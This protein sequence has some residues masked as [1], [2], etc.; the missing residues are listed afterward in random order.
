MSHQATNGTIIV[1]GTYCP[2]SPSF[3]DP[4]YQVPMAA[5]RSIGPATSSIIPVVVWLLLYANVYSIVLQ[6][7]YIA[8]HADT[9]Y[10]YMVYVYLYIYNIII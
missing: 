3:Q 10:I 9:D 2:I 4:G 5:I 8:E 7:I 1:R 6:P